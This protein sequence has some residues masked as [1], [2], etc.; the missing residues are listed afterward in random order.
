MNSNHIEYRGEIFT[1]TDYNGISV[2]MDEDGYYNA[3]KICKDNDKRFS[4]WLQND[5][6]K[7]IL[8][9]IS[10]KLEI[11]M[12]SL[13][14]GNPVSTNSLMFKRKGGNGHNET[15]G[16]W[17]HPKVVHYLA[18]WADLEYAWKVGEI[19]D[20][21]NERIHLKCSSLEDELESVKDELKTVKDD[22]DMLNEEN[23]ILHENTKNLTNNVNELKTRTVPKK[24]N[25]KVLRILIDSEGDM[26]ISANSHWSDRDFERNGFRVVRHYSFP[27]SMN[28]RQLLRDCKYVSNLYFNPIHLD[29]IYE[30]IDS[31]HP[32]DE[33]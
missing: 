11:P 1:V 19:M 25:N 2:I 12:D 27:A 9:M 13:E 31:E 24:T 3:S 32:L 4:N 5:R 6:T 15:Q 33:W 26:K 23:T 7:R 14:T 16:W 29:S 30:I 18:E 28:V 10:T 17:I 22:Y 21:I 8:E 20:A